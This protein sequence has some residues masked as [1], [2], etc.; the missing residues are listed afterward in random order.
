MG[1]GF[2]LAKRFERFLGSI[3]LL[4]FFM[5]SFLIVDK[6]GQASGRQLVGVG[7][8]EFLRIYTE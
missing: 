3:P 4:L 5:L 7:V 8:A 6:S 2:A 1:V